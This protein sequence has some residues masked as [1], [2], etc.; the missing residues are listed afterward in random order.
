M[1]A[2]ALGLSEERRGLRAASRVGTLVG[3]VVLA[4]LTGCRAEEQGRVTAY[5]KGV[6]LGQQDEAL[7]QET[8]DALRQRARKQS[9]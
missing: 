4:A 8:K 2:K 9:F 1:N 6:Y 3:L 7:S 5:E